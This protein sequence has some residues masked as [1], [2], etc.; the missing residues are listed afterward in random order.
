MYKHLI[1]A[2]TAGPE[3][4]RDNTRYVRFQYIPK[5][6]NILSKREMRCALYIYIDDSEECIICF[7]GK[8]RLSFRV[9]FSPIKRVHLIKAADGQ[10]NSIFV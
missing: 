7:V 6:A 8:E 9:K 1:L 2:S 10:N 5:E 4:A 3:H